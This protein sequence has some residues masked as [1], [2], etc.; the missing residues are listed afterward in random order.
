MLFGPV[1]YRL[2]L[3]AQPLDATLAAHIVDTALP[4][5]PP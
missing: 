4:G 2:R 1:Y 3:S 5:L